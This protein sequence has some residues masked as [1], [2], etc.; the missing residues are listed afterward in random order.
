MAY[1][2]N[3][4]NHF[5]LILLF[6]KSDAGANNVV[7]SESKIGSDEVAN[8]DVEVDDFGWVRVTTSS[9]TVDDSIVVEIGSEEE[10]V[11]TDADEA[12]EVVAVFVDEDV[13]WI[14]NLS[15][16]MDFVK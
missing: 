16:E 8:A 13:C 9:S 2:L 10:D 14:D 1:K 11:D 3:I 6:L 12:D 15:P 4:S 7:E 5:K